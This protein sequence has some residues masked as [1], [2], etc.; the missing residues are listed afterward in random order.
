MKLLLL[1]FLPLCASAQTDTLRPVRIDT[2]KLIGT[3]LIPGYGRYGQSIQTRYTYDG[4][5]I[6]RPMD[7]E[8]YIRASGDADA[9]AE[10]DRYVARRQGGVTLII[11]GSIATVAGM[12]GAAIAQANDP[13]KHYVTYTTGGYP[14]TQQTSYVSDKGVGGAIVAMAGTIML[15][16]GAFM[17]IPGNH[18]RHAVQY[19]NRALRQRSISWQ[20]QPYSSGSP[21]GVGLVGRF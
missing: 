15:C 21:A 2:L 13:D 14:Y 7:L 1:L 18:L 11:I 12:T 17:R 16:C 9:N 20:M 10:F 4:I 19:Y 3:D 6:R 5:D 8:K